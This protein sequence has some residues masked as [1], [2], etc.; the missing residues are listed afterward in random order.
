MNYE[1]FRT[2]KS[3]K[4]EAVLKYVIYFR[5]IAL[6]Y[7]VFFFAAIYVSFL[8]KLGNIV[9]SSLY[10]FVF[11]LRNDAISINSTLSLLYTKWY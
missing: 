6:I 5:S 10:V 8:S 11:N 7:K 1:Y 2:P 4:F 9:G 3:I